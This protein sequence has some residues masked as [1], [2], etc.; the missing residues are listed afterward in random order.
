MCFVRNLTADLQASEQLTKLL[1]GQVDNYNHVSQLKRLG[2]DP[3]PSVLSPPKPVAPQ[4]AAPNAGW[5]NFGVVSSAEGQSQ[6]SFL[7][8][9]RTGSYVADG[10]VDG[11]SSPK[12]TRQAALD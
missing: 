11:R 8:P 12:Q 6:D 9:L 4:L 1:H 10:S 2:L 5:A 7:P 3:T